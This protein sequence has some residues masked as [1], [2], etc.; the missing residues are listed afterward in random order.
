MFAYIYTST[1]LSG[2]IAIVCS[3]GFMLAAVIGFLGALKRSAAVI[4]LFFILSLFLTVGEIFCALVLS[5]ASNPNAI[6]V[7]N[8]EFLEGWI[9]VV[10]KVE[11]DNNFL[12]F[13]SKIQSDNQCCGFDSVSDPTQNPA[14][15][16]CAN[17][18]TCNIYL[19]A[20]I[21]DQ[22]NSILTMYMLLL[23][24]NSMIL[25][26]LGFILIRIVPKPV[27]HEVAGAYYY[28]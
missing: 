28:A 5:G 17:M 24:L 3:S 9:S 26:L 25:I 21:A 18:T 13:I 1:R 4:K 8:N 11:Q 15:L 16:N 19:P 20:L 22:V 27:H 10:E 23:S 2:V 6:Q 14:S 12:A 7:R